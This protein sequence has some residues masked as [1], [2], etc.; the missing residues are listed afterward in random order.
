M[1]NYKIIPYDNSE[2]IVYS[3][4]VEEPL[5]NLS[6]IASLFEDLD[7]FVEWLDELVIRDI[8]DFSEPGVIIYQGIL[9]GSRKSKIVELIRDAPYIEKEEFYTQ[10]LIELCREWKSF[11]ENQ[12]KD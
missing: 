7:Y 9:W 12:N 8:P 4:H 3:L 1:I 10:D 6:I 2:K 5:E 11:V